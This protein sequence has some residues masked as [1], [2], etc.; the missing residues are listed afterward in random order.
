MIIYLYVK[1][2]TVSGLKYFGRTIRKDPFKYKGSG[3]YWVNH[4]KK[5]GSNNIKTLEIWGFDSQKL[6]S[7]FA[8]KFSK[9]N[10]IVE[11]EEW[12]NQISENGESFF[13]G[14]KFSDNHKDKIS[15]S[16]KGK[17]VSLE[18]RNKI[19]K[20]MKGKMVGENNPFF[21]KTYEDF[22]KK[23]PKGMLGKHHSE[24]TKSILSKTFKNKSYEEIYG[25][26]KAKKQK[27]KLSKSLKGKSKKTKGMTYEQIYG[28]EKAKEQKRIRTEK[29]KGRK[30][31]IKNP[32]KN[33]LCQHCNKEF[34]PGNYKRHIN[35]LTTK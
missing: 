34:N 13:S 31:T 16:N 2:H 19:S 6:C 23:H 7:E 11:S 20:A 15:E 29:V 27:E 4:Y 8:L 26:E 32:P 22:G 17:T 24:E 18:T 28:E 1:Q 3:T 10:N 35:R 30:L 25:E 33:I 12:A 9:E 14:L 21:S 5:Y